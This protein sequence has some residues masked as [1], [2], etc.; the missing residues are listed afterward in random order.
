M[1]IY[2]DVNREIDCENNLSSSKNYF[3]IC[4]GCAEDIYKILNGC[5]SEEFRK[6]CIKFIR[7]KQIKWLK[8]ADKM[9]M[10][11]LFEENKTKEIRD[12]K[13]NICFLKGKKKWMDN[14]LGIVKPKELEIIT[15]I[16]NQSMN[17]K[18]TPDDIKDIFY[19]PISKKN[20]NLSNH[21]TNINGKIQSCDAGHKYIMYEQKIDRNVISLISHDHRQFFTDCIYASENRNENQENRNGKPRKQK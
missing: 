21:I 16:V 6:S 19:D 12:E 5:E 3:R 17:G 1:E 13:R 2:Q 7:Q 11:R 15:E 10:N 14:H 18:H 20:L 4:K 8:N 9:E